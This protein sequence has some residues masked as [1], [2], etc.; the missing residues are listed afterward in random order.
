M[1][2]RILRRGPGFVVRWCLIHF[3]AG[4]LVDEASRTKL[5]EGRLDHTGGG[6]CAFAR[7]CVEH[8]VHARKRGAL[9]RE[10]VGVAPLERI[11]IGGH[12]GRPIPDVLALVATLRYGRSR[13]PS[14]ERLTEAHHLHAAVV[15]VEL[16]MHDVAR[17][18][19]HPCQRVAICRPAGVSGM[20]RTGRV[21]ADVLD[22]HRSTMADLE[23][24]VAVDAVVQHGVDHLVQ[25]RRGEAEVDE[26]RARDLDRRDVGWGGRLDC[27]Y[28]LGRQLPRVLP[29]R[30]GRRQCRVG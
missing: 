16:A 25:P 6:E 18:A 15:D 24:R 14:S 1:A 28:Q 10:G 17:A 9:V 12:L 5:V 4:C 27:R 21:G 11:D 13:L 22:V 3:G 29:G 19:E 2:G 7:P 26:T 8:D 20:Q 30:L 23:L